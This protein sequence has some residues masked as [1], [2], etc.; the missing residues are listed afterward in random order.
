MRNK[1]LMTLVALLMAFTASAQI[2]LLYH[3]TDNPKE[4]YMRN[5]IDRNKKLFWMDGDDDP[6]YN[7]TNYSKNGNKE[8]FTLIE[9]ES[10]GYGEAI[11]VKVNTEL[12]SAGQT[13]KITYKY[14]Y[15][16]TPETYN[17]TNETDVREHNR[18]VRYYNEL[19]GNPPEQGVI[20]EGLSVG[21]GDSSPAPAVETPSEVNEANKVTDT[22][23]DAVNKVKGLFKK[24]K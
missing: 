13:V 21:G 24:K 8:S 2:E 23:K 16:K 17:V 19:A 11:T 20:N 14:S 18:L 5:V 7:I 22:A 9:K 12:G 3:Y 4:A 6:C 1:T 10:S 15:S